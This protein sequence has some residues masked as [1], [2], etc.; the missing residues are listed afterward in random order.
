MYALFVRRWR[1]FPSEITDL[2]PS[3]RC[4]TSQGLDDGKRALD[5]GQ[6]VS[7]TDDRICMMSSPTGR[8]KGSA[9]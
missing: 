7:Q 9:S 5:S 4:L 1:R 8:E 3:C 2:L 6:V